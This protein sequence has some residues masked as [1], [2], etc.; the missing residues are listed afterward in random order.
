M[1]ERWF[2]SQ[3][4]H[5][6]PKLAFWGKN[7][8]DQAKTHFCVWENLYKL[9]VVEGNFT[10]VQ[11]YNTLNKPVNVWPFFLVEN[12]V[13]QGYKL[14]GDEGLSSLVKSSRFE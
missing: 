4:F 11:L 13:A 6:S 1:I 5:L 9:V 14:S 12:K 3:F 7:L 2:H 8:Q 10:K